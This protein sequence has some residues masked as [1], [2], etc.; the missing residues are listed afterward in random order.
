LEFP[1][2]NN[3]IISLSIWFKLVVSQY[4]FYKT[5]WKKCL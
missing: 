3:N 2:I 5:L 1:Y 4:H